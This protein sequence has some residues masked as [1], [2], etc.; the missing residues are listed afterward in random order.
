[1]EK[2]EGV[3]LF[4]E[5]VTKTLLDLGVL[6][7][8][9]RWASTAWSRALDE[10]SV[11]DTIQGIIMARLDRLGEDGKRTVQ[12]ASVI[13]RQF[14]VRL[15]ERIA[16]LTDA[17]GRPAGRVEGAR[18]HLRAGAA[19]PS[20][21]TS[22]S[23][24]SSRTSPTTACSS[25]GADDLH[26]A[27]GGTPS[28]SS[29]PTG[30]PSTTRSWPTTSSGRGVG[31]GLRVPRPLRRQGARRLR[32]PGGPGPLRPGGGGG[33]PARGDDSAPAD[34]GHA[35]AARA[36]ADRPGPVPGRGPSPSQADARGGPRRRPTGGRGPG[37]RRAGL[38]PLTRQ[39]RRTTSLTQS[40]R[41]KQASW[42]SP[43]RRRRSLLARSH[44]ILGTWTR[45]KRSSPRA[46]GSSTKPPHRAPGQGSPGS[47]WLPRAAAGL[48]AQLAGRFRE[49]HRPGAARR[50]RPRRRVHDGFNEVRG[51]VAP[52][53]L[54]SAA[55]TIRKALE[56]IPP[57]ARSP[58]SG[59]TRSSS[60]A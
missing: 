48:Q 44:F 41:P 38:G 13:G 6:R 50:K 45:W 39:C 55:V 25:S 30:S 43:A 40:R 12:L 16:G 28:R 54:T 56:V 29:M 59:T 53:S 46:S 22:S 51:D 2:A 10:V 26:R 18:D 1:M 23:T 21:P 4:V 32:Q 47:S 52:A 49:R 27:V 3:P 31:E 35:P 60:D 57:G 17:A 8:E 9:E 34:H 37:L 14:L 15:L 11:P 5:E 24:R 36:A 20:P 33:V 42:P 19:C 58:G 7:R